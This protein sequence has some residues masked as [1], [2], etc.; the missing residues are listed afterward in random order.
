MKSLVLSVLIASACAGAAHAQADPAIAKGKT[1]V[2][3]DCAGCHQVSGK[4][5]SPLPEA[6]AF[7]TLGAKYDFDGLP[8]A[9]KTGVAPVMPT[10]AYTAADGKAVA[11]Y[12]KSL[13][14]A[15]KA[16]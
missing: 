15:P 3:R 11:A 8:V 4:G 14:P 13:Q 9:L 10:F 12:L 7:H 16:K 5:T 1:I 6:P 2:Q